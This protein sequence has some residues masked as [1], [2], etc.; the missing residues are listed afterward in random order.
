MLAWLWSARGG[1]QAPREPEPPPVY[2]QQA[3]FV[4]AARKA[5][6]AG[7]AAGVKTALIEWGRLEWP[8]AAP[9]SI[10]ELAERIEEP[11]AGELRSLS[12]ASYGRAGA[13]WDGDALSTALRKIAALRDEKAVAAAAHPLPP[14]LPPAT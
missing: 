6:S 13:N 9:R 8:A 10:G 5:A 7:D 14:L 4:K 2:K 3:K 12:A 1:K 11:L